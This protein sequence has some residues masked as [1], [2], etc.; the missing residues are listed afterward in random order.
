M[1]DFIVFDILLYFLVGDKHILKSAWNQNWTFMAFSVI[2]YSFIRG[3][4]TKILALYTCYT[5]Y[6]H[7]FVYIFVQSNAFN[8]KTVPLTNQ[9]QLI[10]NNK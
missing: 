4:R 2:I 7:G 9:S 5:F 8:N 1:C 3:K 6:T 10:S